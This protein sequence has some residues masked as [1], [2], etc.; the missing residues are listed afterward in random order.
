VGATKECA[1]EEEGGRER[2]RESEKAADSGRE[3]ASRTESERMVIVRACTIAT[4][5]RKEVWSP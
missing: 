2:E 1:K 5:E 4:A 3:I